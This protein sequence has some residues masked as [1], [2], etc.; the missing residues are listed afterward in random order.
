MVWG[1]WSLVPHLV[2][3][4]NFYAVFFEF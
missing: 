2:V 4:L 3:Q 1:G